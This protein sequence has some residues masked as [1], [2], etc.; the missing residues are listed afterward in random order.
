MSKLMTRLEK[1]NDF[2]N[3]GDNLRARTV[4]LQ[5]EGQALDTEFGDWLKTEFGLTGQHHVSE[6]LKVAL[7]TS[8]E[9]T[10]RIIT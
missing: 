10:P 8:V 2:K 7:E 6:I 5:A 9:P 1:L 3:R 4:G